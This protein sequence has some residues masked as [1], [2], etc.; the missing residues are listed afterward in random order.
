MNVTHGSLGALDRVQRPRSSMQDFLSSRNPY[1]QFAATGN[2]GHRGLGD[3]RVVKR[4][5]NPFCKGDEKKTGSSS[6][7]HKKDSGK[8]TTN[9]SSKG[10]EKESEK[11]KGP[12][13]K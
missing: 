12:K 5:S 3:E 1:D 10:P 13:N 8:K 7:S 11:K 6:M 2:P 4:F 9:S